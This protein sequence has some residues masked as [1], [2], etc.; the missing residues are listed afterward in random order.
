[1]LKLTGRRIAT[2]VQ[3]YLLNIDDWSEDLVPLLAKKECLNLSQAHWNVI[4]FIR[5]FYLE[6]NITPAIRILISEMNKKYGIEYI[7]SNYLYCLFPKGPAQQATKL[8]GL[9][10][11]IHCI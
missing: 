4:R 3:G 10:K 6:F 2:D 9:P 11:P 7:N 8:A 5:T 1:M